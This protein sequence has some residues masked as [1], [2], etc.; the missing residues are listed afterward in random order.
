M[1]VVMAG[2]KV[3][4]KTGLGSAVDM[5]IDCPLATTKVL[6]LII[7]LIT[8][9]WILQGTTMKCAISNTSPNQCLS[10]HIYDR[11]VPLGLE[12]NIQRVEVIF[13]RGIIR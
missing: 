6:F 5:D 11:N 3:T 1:M 2:V 8:L 9:F 12:Y 4:K 10:A 7:E 13:R